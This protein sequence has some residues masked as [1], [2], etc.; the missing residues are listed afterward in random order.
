MF[1]QGLETGSCPGRFPRITKTDL[2]KPINKL[3]VKR[4]KYALKKICDPV[5]LSQICQTKG[6][7]VGQ[8]EGGRWTA[9]EIR[10]YH[11]VIDIEEDKE[12]KE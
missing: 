7:V 8:A 4:I 12:E 1:F 2:L 9:E 5:L 6:R 11:P 10:V 3:A